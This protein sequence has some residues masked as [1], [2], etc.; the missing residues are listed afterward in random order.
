MT[1]PGWCTEH[2]DHREDMY[3]EAV[4]AVSL[5]HAAGGPAVTL[6][7]RDSPL[8][9]RGPARISVDGDANLGIEQARALSAAIT[10]A[11]RA[12]ARDD[13]LT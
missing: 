8:D 10:E 13:S 1:C 5:M 4:H 2:H 3:D 9:M 6:W 12:A 7:R 11:V